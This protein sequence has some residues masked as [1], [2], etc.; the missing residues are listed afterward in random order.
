MMDVE[1]NVIESTKA[2]LFVVKNGGLLTPQL[3]HA[4]ICGV[5][6]DLILDE[7]D[8]SGI[9]VLETS[10]SLSALYAADEAFLC[11]SLIGIWPIHS[12]AA[13]DRHLFDIGPITRSLQQAL[14]NRGAVP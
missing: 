13:T 4:G 2:N 8:R 10:L 9:P 11:N 1:N 14:K 12:I 5:M 7:A 6:R 3:H